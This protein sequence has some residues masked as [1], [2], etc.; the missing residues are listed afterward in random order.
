MSPCAGQLLSLLAG[1]CVGCVRLRTLH[2]E[3]LLNILKVVG[4]FGVNL[5]A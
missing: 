2:S 3:L 5:R 4:M 1:T